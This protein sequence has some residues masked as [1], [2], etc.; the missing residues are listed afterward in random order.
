MPRMRF[1]GVGDLLPDLALVPAETL[2]FCQANGLHLRCSMDA[3]LTWGPYHA[4]IEECARRDITLLPILE[5]TWDNGVL[6]YPWTQGERDY[7]QT[8]C[9]DV[10]TV[11]QWQWNAGRPS[12]AQFEL[13]NEPNFPR[14]ETGGPPALNVYNYVGNILKPGRTGIKQ[15]G[16]PAI[17]VGGL[18]FGTDGGNAGPRQ[19]AAYFIKALYG[20]ENSGAGSG[21]SYAPLF[22]AISI[23]PYGKT[24]AV[25]GGWYSDPWSTQT[26]SSAVDEIDRALAARGANTDPLLLTETG[27]P[28]ALSPFN[29]T[30][31]RTFLQQLWSAVAAR[32]AVKC[33][34]NWHVQDRPGI[35]VKDTKGL[36]R[37]DWQRKPAGDWFVSKGGPWMENFPQD[38]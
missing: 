28:S 18:S 8:F 4:R 25:G 16:N 32:P 17:V 26:V 2:N 24:R 37:A 35:P 31:Q 34:S 38:A 1:F 23:H 30:S 11:A 13:Y 33:F 22:D 14:Q 7:W 3:R 36:H 29:E 5:W 27:R 15:A 12:I 9:R 21:I 6:R 10:T 19:D 20:T